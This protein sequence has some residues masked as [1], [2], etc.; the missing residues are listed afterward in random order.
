MA[1]ANQI[2]MS[3]CSPCHG[4]DG[5]GNGPVSAALN[6]KPRSFKDPE[7]QKSVTDEHIEKVIL[8]GG[9]AVGKAPTMP[10]NPDLAEKKAVIGAL[11]E[12]IRKM[13]AA[14]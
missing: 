13:G 3:R 8:Q 9:P 5:S 14:Q 2:M 7:W 6:P 12:L 4:T 11:R 10:P 1:E